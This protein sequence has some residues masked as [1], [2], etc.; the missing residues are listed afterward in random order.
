MHHI[1][2][3]CHL[4]N[5]DSRGRSW[6]ARLA[7]LEF[8]DWAEFSLAKAVEACNSEPVSLTWSQL[9]LLSVLVVLRPGQLPLWK[10]KG[11][12][13]MATSVIIIDKH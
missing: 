10:S 1:S 4:G 5:F 9:P 13:L 2:L 11:F 8:A 6:E 12:H 7:S 3:I